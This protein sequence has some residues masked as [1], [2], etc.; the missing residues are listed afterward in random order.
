MRRAAALLLAA[1]VLGC[2]GAPSNRE[3]A[4]DVEATASVDRSELGFGD[5]LTLTIEVRFDPGREIELPHP[6]TFDGFRTVD[7]GTVDGGDDDPRVERQWYRLR[8]ERVGSLELPALTVRHRAAASPGAAGARPADTWSTVTT[9]PLAITVR[10]LLPAGGE[11]P[12][13]IRDIKPLQPIARSRPWLWVA[14]ATAVVVA[15]G[16]AIALLLRR[17]RARPA[18]AAP[19]V[20]AHEVALA[21]LDRLAALELA[22]DEAVRRFHFALSEVVRA[23][24][25]G[26]FGLNATDLTTEE[27]LSALDRLA[28]EAAP[29]SSLRTFLRETDRVKFAAHRPDRGDVAAVLARARGFV[30]ETRPL[31]EPVGA[32]AAREAA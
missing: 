17:R 21:A 9:E 23:Y 26:R 1:A 6:G 5:D 12:P 24:V 10:S 13:E 4:D 18:P 27:I 28:L 3:L 32:E 29:A 16:A 25:E 22:D 20:P 2:A 19:P 31:E 30:E 7:Q 14:V 11:E 15:I 8:A